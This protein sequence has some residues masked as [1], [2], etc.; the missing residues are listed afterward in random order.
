[1][2]EFTLTGEAAAPVEDVW[3]LLFDPTRFPEWWA[4]IET[5]QVGSEGGLTIWQDGYPDLPLRQELH[6]DRATGRVTMSCQVFDVEFAWQLAE[7]GDGTRITVRVDI[8]PDHAARLLEPERDVI[9]ASLVAL[10]TLAEAE[11]G[12]V[13]SQVR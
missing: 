6:T 2:P 1:M 12:T 9:A 13:S 10:A 7:H 3:K 5:V 8:P 11:T 4:G